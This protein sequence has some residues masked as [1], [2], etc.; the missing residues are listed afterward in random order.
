MSCTT[1]DDFPP[2]SLQ[3]AVIDSVVAPEKL[4]LDRINKF[5]VY[6]SNPSD[7]HVFFDFEFYASQNDR[8]IKVITA[9]NANRLPCESTDSLGQ[10]KVEFL[11]QPRNL[12]TFKFHF[13]SGY[14]SNG[15]A[16]YIIK[17]VDTEV[18]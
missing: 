8:F 10:Q 5:E 13:F 1:D 9:A 15:L 11:F 4:Q 2:I 7:C 17:E 16:Q 18:F 6:Y 3:E 12:F 14:D